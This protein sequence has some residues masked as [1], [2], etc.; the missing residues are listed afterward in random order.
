MIN[1]SDGSTRRLVQ[2]CAAY[3]AFYVVTGVSV[4][5]FLGSSSHGLP[6]MQGIEFL[7]YSTLGGNG[8]CLAVVFA[9]RW[10]KL[11]SA[12]PVT[13]GPL[14]FPREFLYIVPSGICTAIVIPTTTLMYTLPI[15]VM[16]AMVMMRGSVIVISRAVDAIQIKQGIL[17]KRVFPEEDVAVLLALAAVAVDLFGAG[18]AK[19]PGGAASGFDFVHSPA[20]V[21]ILASYIVSYALRIYIMNYYKNTRPPSVPLHN[22]G[23]FA[24]EQLAASVT[25]GAVCLV[26]Y[27][28]PWHLAQLDAFRQ[29]IAAPRPAWRM[30]TLAGVAYGMVAFFSVFIFMFKGRTA[31]F[32]GLV[33]RLTSL[34][35]GTTATLVWWLAFGGAFPKLYDWVSLGFI[36][37]AV[38]C[39]TRAEKKRSA[40]LA[41]DK[42]TAAATA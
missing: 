12:G 30:A 18:E 3:F 37:A 41:S 7:V 27:F 24:I 8:I 31:T 14:T 2:L 35:A 22:E 32:A 17:K 25:M 33:N 29:A 23:F 16:V 40:A 20:A 13:V 4:K 36:L 15:S 39:L 6:G 10:Y 28:A 38:A 11:R 34:V 1:S 42:P 9:A 19:G 5:Y 26:L 21:A